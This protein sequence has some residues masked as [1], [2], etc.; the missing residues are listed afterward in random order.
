MHDTNIYLKLTALAAIVYMLSAFPLLIFSRK[1]LPRSI[2]PWLEYLT[3][4]ILAAMIFPSLFVSV[5]GSR[6]PHASPSY[7]A[8]ALATA[9]AFYFLRKRVVSLLIGVT[10]FYLVHAYVNS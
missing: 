3:P 10:V 6:V 1:E 5:Q 2:K 7:L 8:G 9:I 4:S